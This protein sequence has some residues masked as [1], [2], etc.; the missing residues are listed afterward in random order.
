MARK[1]VRRITYKCPRC[2]KMMKSSSGWTLHVKKCCPEQRF[3]KTRISMAIEFDIPIPLDGTNNHKR[4]IPTSPLEFFKMAFFPREVRI[5]TYGGRKIG[6]PEIV[7]ASLIGEPK[8][9]TRPPTI[10]EQW[11][12]KRVEMNRD[13]KSAIAECK[14]VAHILLGDQK[15]KGMITTSDYPK[16]INFAYHK[17]GDARWQSILTITF[18]LNKESVR[19][20]YGKLRL[21]W[22]KTLNVYEEFKLADPECM[23]KIQEFIKGV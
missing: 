1:A 9:S 23:D 15:D 22:P 6:R 13:K 11:A 10:S 3:R 18:L 14:R 21:S 17:G 7:S 2:G 4:P 20:S 16:W 8:I 12:M 5:S 19:V